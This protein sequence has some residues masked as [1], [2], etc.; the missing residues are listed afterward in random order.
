MS[1]MDS[2]PLEVIKHHIFPC[3]DYEG[4]INLN[5]ACLSKDE[6][7]CT[8]L[9]M[10]EVFKFH[11]KIILNKLKYNIGK[12]F[13]KLPKDEKHSYHLSLINIL[14]KYT[15]IV[16]YFS[17]L[18]SSIIRKYTNFADSEYYEY[19]DLDEKYRI[20]NESKELLKRIES[21][22]FICN[23]SLDSIDEDDWSPIYHAYIPERPD[24]MTYA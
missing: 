23:I 13:S 8:R 17:S 21:F 11:L 3:L 20:I 2:L 6:Y 14:M 19:E 18:R 10:E 24:L 16:Q 1:H 12:I 7:I 9:N 22:P 4:R 5:K 15:F